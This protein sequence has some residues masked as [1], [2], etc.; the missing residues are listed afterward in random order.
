LQNEL[1]VFVGKM[2][3][4]KMKTIMRLMMRFEHKLKQLF[5]NMNL[6][7]L[8]KMVPSRLIL[9]YALNDELIVFVSKIG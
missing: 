6:K 9:H 4:T 1:N 8:I 2:V 3:S 7:D 5:G